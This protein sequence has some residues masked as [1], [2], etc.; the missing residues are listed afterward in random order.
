[1]DGCGVY[2]GDHDFDGGVRGS[3]AA[4]RVGS[5]FFDG[6][7]HYRSR[8][9]CLHVCDVG[10]AIDFRTAGNESEATRDRGDAA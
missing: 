10:R 1:M 4:E 3:E 7:N 2:V 6:D 8:S 5:G 9:V